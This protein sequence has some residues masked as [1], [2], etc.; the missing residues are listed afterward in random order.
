MSCPTK[1][2]TQTL[3]QA[4]DWLILKASGR[5]SQ[6]QEQ[7]LGQWRSQKAEHEQAW[8]AAC[9][10]QSLIGRVPESLGHQVLDRERLDRRTLLKV[11]A[12][13]V[14]MPATAWSLTTQPD[15]QRWTA[16]ARTATG[17]QRSISLPDGSE[18]TLNTD[19]AVDINYSNLARHIVLHRGE[20]M[21]STAQD[22]L[23]PIRPFLVTTEHGEIRA[24]GNQFIIRT[25]LPG[26]AETTA[27]TGVIAL[28]QA[29]AVRPSSELRETLVEANQQ[30]AFTRQK[31]YPPKSAPYSASA[32][33][34]GQLIADNQRLSEFLAEVARYRS[35]IIRVD[36]AVADLRISGVFQL[37][38]TDQILSSLAGT[39]PVRI[40]RMTGYWVTVTPA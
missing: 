28:H 23:Q 8:Q 5:L 31:V 26:F 32:W 25:Q 30:A 34:K 14:V 29:V 37:K 1:P 11:L 40:S 4:A 17:E 3:E 27:H 21:I 16:D 12:A 20:I 10:L 18:L 2:S 6:K 7:A 38:N 19:S 9:R 35:G 15:W 24:L 33:V 39:L 36:P 22:T 13:A